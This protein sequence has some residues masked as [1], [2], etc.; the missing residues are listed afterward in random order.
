M[1]SFRESIIRKKMEP[2]TPVI[3]D[4]KCISPGEGRLL[5]QEEAVRRAAEIEAAGAAAISVVTEPVDFGGSLKLLSD[6]VERVSIPVLRKDFIRTSEEIDI[7]IEHG[8][9]AVLLMCS[10]MSRDEMKDCYSYALERGIE[11]LVE[12]HT[13]EE[14]LFAEELG[15]TLIGINNRDILKLEKDG[16]TVS[17]TLNM[18][19]TGQLKNPDRVLISESGIMTADDVRA[20]IGAGADAVLIG[21]A[22]WKAEDPIEYYKKLAS[23]S[24]NQ[25]IG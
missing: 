5:T 6:I 9:S 14:M 3:T 25:V 18:M 23:V 12:T 1:K 17:T 19:S 24:L 11:P 8:A 4:F 15:A 7:S 16:G 13:A 22:I 20:A 21:T 2:G 10:V